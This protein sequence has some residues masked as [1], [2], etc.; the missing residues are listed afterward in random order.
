[1]MLEPSDGKGKEEVAVEDLQT[2]GEN[3]G[4]R[5]CNVQMEGN[6]KVAQ[7]EETVC[8]TNCEALEAEGPQND[9]EDIGSDSSDMM[10]TDDSDLEDAPA[11][12]SDEETK[13]EV[14]LTDAEIEELVAEFLEVESKA[15]EA[16][17]SLEE[18][19]LARVQSDV[20]EELSDSLHGDA[21]EMAVS[22]EM[23]TFKEE[24]E[25]MLDDL[26]T[27]SSFLLEQLDG[28]GIE[29]PSL[30]KWIESQAPNGC[31]TEAWKKRAHWVGSQITSELNQSIRDAE[32]SLQLDRP[33][34]RQHGKLLEEGA[35]GYLAKKVF[36]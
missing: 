20:R 9:D 33:V 7:V 10:P 22:T 34:R 5:E 3:I 18:E 16:Q 4:I 14:P 30:Y 6:K 2:E 15:A 17:E 31:C 25:A 1:M 12:G 36:F 19:S 23:K 32:S 21:L 29:L 24:W 26:E 13:S 8:V 11:S 27:Q 35:S 28:A